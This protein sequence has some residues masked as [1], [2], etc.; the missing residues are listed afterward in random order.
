[1]KRGMRF[2]MFGVLGIAAVAAFGLLTQWLWNWLVPGLFNGPALTFWQ[3]LGV[4]VLSEILFGSF[5][6]GGRGCHRYGHWGPDGYKSAWA[7][8]WRG[9]SPE[10]REKFKQKMSEKWC[11]SE[12]KDAT[13][14]STPSESGPGTSA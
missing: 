3:A 6:R 14:K 4:I 5:G 12:K 2:L 8:K 10:D 11:Y 7:A 9:M 1:M 13:E